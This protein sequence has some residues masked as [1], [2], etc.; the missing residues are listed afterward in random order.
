M[1]AET[2]LD[3]QP[4]EVLVMTAILG[5]LRSFDELVQRYRAA[6]FRVARAVAGAELAEDAVQEALLLAFRALPS[7]E[8]PASFAAWLCAITRRAALRMSQH[9]RRE[10]DR[11]IE[12]DEAVLEFSE[13]LARPFTLPESFENDEVRAAVDSLP[14]AYRLIVQLR[15]YDEM[16]LKRIASF[17]DLPLTTV[18]WRLHRAK[19]LVRE[20][21][22][23]VRAVPA[24][25]AEAAQ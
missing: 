19:Q 12:L 10:N 7:I 8:E 24:Q 22:Q 13:A 6:A 23:P 2:R 3:K 1:A 16:P 17:L 25:L 15:F 14:A 9:A 5:D 11:R 21:L 18:K 4:D 20:Q